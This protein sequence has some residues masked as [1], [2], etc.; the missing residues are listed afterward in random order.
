MHL[1][2]CVI[3]LSVELDMP[4]GACS[5]GKKSVARSILVC[6]TL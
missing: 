5:G 4:C 1:V 6:K 3:M 2:I